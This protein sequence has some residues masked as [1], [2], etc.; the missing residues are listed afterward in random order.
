MIPDYLL[1]KKMID[2]APAASTFWVDDDN[3]F[4][5]TALTRGNLS[6][7]FNA[8]RQ[9]SETKARF[10]WNV[11]LNDRWSLI[12]SPNLEETAWELIKQDK[13]VNDTTSD[14]KTGSKNF[15]FGRFDL[16]VFPQMANTSAF[17]SGSKFIGDTTWILWPSSLRFAPYEITYYRGQKKPIIEAVDMPATLL[18]FGTRGYWDVAIN[19]RER[20][21]VSRQ[22]ATA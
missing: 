16:K 13:I 10:N 5:G 20:T 4:D 2:Q 12:V 15:W 19:E 21:A 11:M 17:T 14:T 3:S 9:Y 8:I 7:R 6:A 22:T 1:G 18:G